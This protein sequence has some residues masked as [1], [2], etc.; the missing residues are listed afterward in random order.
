[1]QPDSTHPTS[2][3]VAFRYGWII[4]LILAVVEVIILLIRTFSGVANLS[5]SSSVSSTLNL[6]SSIL[7]ILLG[8]TGFLLGLAAY[9]VAG[10]LASRQTGK[11][12]TGVFAGMWTGG[13]YGIIG[14]IASIIL[15]FTV[16]IGPAIE[17]YNRTY[18]SV[19]Q[20]DSLRTVLIASVLIGSIIGI[21]LAIGWGAGLGALGGLIGRNSWRKQHPQQP[22]PGQPY[23]GQPYPPIQQ[24][25]PAQGYPAQ[26]PWPYTPPQPGYAPPPSG[27]AYPYPARPDQPSPQWESGRSASNSDRTQIDRS[28]RPPE[29]SPG[30]VP[31][32]RPDT[33]GPSEPENPYSS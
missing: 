26:Q 11:V 4:G 19:T 31:Q 7:S 27:N 9:F 33:P 21:A 28:Y 17:L 13:F 16:T 10:I 20:V 18:H 30:A 32:L 15:F 2:G 24:Y 12:S 8:I 3:R 29:Q 25:P 6:G 22:Y 23:P 14:C 5:T 1:M